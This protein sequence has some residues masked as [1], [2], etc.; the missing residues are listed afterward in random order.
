M[1]YKFVTEREIAFVNAINREVIQHVVQQ[2]VRYYEILLKETNVHKLYRESIKK[3]WNAP[4][5]IFARV[6]YGN[7]TVTTTNFVPDAQFE[8]DVFFHTQELQERNVSPKEGDFIEYGRVFYEITSV[9]QPQIVF[10][11]INN[12]IMTKCTTHRAREGQFSAGGSSEESID[13]GSMPTNTVVV[14]K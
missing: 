4:V 1:S 14:N 10:G 13:R 11:E 7:S 9:T 3:T 12:K 8:L 5:D 6:M 2:S